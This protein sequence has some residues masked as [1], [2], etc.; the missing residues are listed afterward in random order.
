[1]IL[2]SAE[3]PPHRP[4]LTR[5][6]VPAALITSLIVVG[7][8]FGIWIRIPLSAEQLVERGNAALSQGD[9]AKAAQQAEQAVHQSP[10]L[11]AGWKLQAEAQGRSHQYEQATDALHRFAR[12]SPREGSQLALR[13]GKE[14][15]MR[16]RIR[17]ARIALQ[18]AEKDADL[19]IESLK[20]Q[21]QIAAVTGHARETVRC[22]LELLKRGSITRGEMLLVTSVAPGLDDLDRLEALLRADPSDPGPNLALA[23]HELNLNHYEAAER[24]LLMITQADPDDHE[25]Q[26][27]LAELYAHFLPEKFYPWHDRLPANI[28][29]DSRIW[30]ARGQWLADRGLTEPAIRSLHEA[31]QREPE[32]LSTTALLG[33]LLKSVNEAELGNA[34]S[35][36]GH[37]LQRIVDLNGR[38]HEPRAS[39]FVI[40]M[41]DE[42]EATG[43]YRE[44]IGW[45]VVHAVGGGV[46]PQLIAA[47]KRRIEVAMPPAL[48]RTSPGSLPGKDFDWNRF[49]LPDWKQL[50]PSA[51]SVKQETEPAAPDIQFQD[52]GP[53]AGLD[54]RFVNSSVPQEGRRI[55]E[56]MGAGVAV[57]DFDGDGWPDLYFPQGN[58]S[59]TTPSRL[60]S[61][62]LYRNQQ[63][64]R[65]VE[66]T[67]QGGIHEISY[68][69]GVSVGDYDNDGFPDIYVANLGRNTLFHNQGDG[70][71]SDVTEQAGLKQAHWTVSCAMA[72]LNGDGL[73]EL[74]DVNYV[75][76]PDLLTG[77]CTDPHGRRSVCRPTVFDPTLDTVCLNQGAGQFLEQQ[78]ECGLDRPQGMGLGL[79]IADFNDDGRLDVF[80]ANDMTANFLLIND[81]T[82]PDEPLH[83]HDEAILRNVALDQYGL[84]QACMGVACAD[85]NR[86]AVPDLLVTNFAKES[87]TLYLSQ[88]GGFFQD[89]TQEADLRKPSFDPLG[90][91]AQFLDADNDG[92]ND[93]AVLNGHIDEFVNQPF[94]MK[95][96]LF[97]GHAGNRFTE[98]FASQAGDLF[99]KLRL[100]RGLAVLDWNRDGQTDFVATDLEDAVLLAENQSDHRHHSLEIKLVGTQSNR[101]AIGAKLRIT[102]TQ[103]DERF[104]Q[105]TAGDG[106]QC[107]N[108]RILRMGVGLLD[109]VEQIEIRWPSGQITRA[110]HVRVDHKWLWIEG[111]SDRIALPSPRK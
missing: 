46:D 69:Q 91:G 84:A 2:K 43:R 32:Q 106:Y 110:D 80:V 37:R 24:F 40:P 21:E 104:L 41:L 82:S 85:L 6:L 3:K 102:V 61:D 33:Q 65:F 96:Q 99:D 31:L 83:F 97:R 13:L 4:A 77:Y 75:H 48:S 20:L 67:V 17:P 108:E 11:A 60:H 54:F 18:L 62:R 7:I 1:M 8:G 94:R 35:E 38:M 5:V 100:G 111:I 74:F 63:G 47:R 93:L 49:P 12:F 15:M 45:C 109:E 89:R 103:G 26:G 73:P 101:D 25:A 98:I 29:D 30:S 64:E 90:F 76:G 52:R 105:V 57:L 10:N 50:K 28:Q 19:A 92:W 39:E 58:T 86:D 68:S 66:V 27:T 22:I 78:H 81:Q 56:T 34:F 53:A 79:V 51:N 70:T 36:R 55:Y 14:W 59:Q 44:A 9:F 87:N 42:L 95:M 72:D 107:S 16:N 23:I 71:F 88:P